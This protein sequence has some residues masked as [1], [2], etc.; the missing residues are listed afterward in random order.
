[1]AG[2]QELWHQ[3]ITLWNQIM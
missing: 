2:R 3:Q 1:L